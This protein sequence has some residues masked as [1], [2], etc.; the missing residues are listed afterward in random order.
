MRYVVAGL[1]EINRIAEAQAAL[2]EL[3]RLNPSLAFVQNSKPGST[4]TGRASNTSM[5]TS[6]RQASN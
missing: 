5:T 3:K 6:A 1:A 4:P 2:V